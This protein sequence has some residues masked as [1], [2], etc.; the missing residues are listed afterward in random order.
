STA[1]GVAVA[2]VRNSLESQKR[3]RP[4]SCLASAIARRPRACRFDPARVKTPRAPKP[5]E[6]PTQAGQGKRAEKLSLL[7]LRSEERFVL[8]IF[9]AAAFLHKQ[10]PWWTST[11]RL[12]NRCAAWRGVSDGLLPKTGRPAPGL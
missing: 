3:A 8:S 4:L 1:L 10:D 5:R 9:R 6:W 7:K 2:R 11:A 12:A